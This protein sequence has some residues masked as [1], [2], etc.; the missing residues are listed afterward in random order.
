[1]LKNGDLDRAPR[2]PRE[3]RGTSEFADLPLP[4]GFPSVSKPDLLELACLR[5]LARSSFGLGRPVPERD[6]SC[7][8]QCQGHADVV[9]PYRLYAI[10][11][12]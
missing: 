5:W 11:S 9:A 3:M 10:D 1:M 12:P 2:E 4:P 6:H 7:P 8:Y